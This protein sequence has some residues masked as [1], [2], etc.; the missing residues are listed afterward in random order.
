MTSAQVIIV[1]GAVL[2][3]QILPQL[4]LRSGSKIA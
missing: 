2:G 3:G 4:I 1:V